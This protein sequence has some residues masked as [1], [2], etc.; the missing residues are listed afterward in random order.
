M[1]CGAGDPGRPGRLRARVA[2][3]PVEELGR[4]Y[5]RRELPAA[6]QE[7]LAGFLAR[8]GVHGTAEIDLGRQRWNE[9]PAPVLQ[10][11]QSYL[12]I[13]DPE[14]APDRI[15]ARGAAAGER[16]AGRLAASLRGGPHGRVRAA[17][18]RFAAGRVRALA[19]M[20]EYPKF[21]AVRLLGLAHDALLAS[22]A[23]L[24]KQGLLSAAGDVFFL[25]L[26]ELRELA[27]D[28]GGDAGRPQALVAERRAAYEREM[29]RTQIPRVLLS[30]GRA[31]YGGVAAAAG[32]AANTLAGSPVSP[33][34]AEGPVRVVFDP[35]QA[36]LRPGEILVCPGTDPAWTPLFLAAAG[37]VMEVGGLMTH[38]A[39]V[40]REYGI[41]AVASVYE[42]TTRL[43]TGQRVRVDGSN[44]VVRVLDD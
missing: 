35:H 30:D 40:A 24:A 41:P 28:A 14:A 44:G 2:D 43:R 9:D 18:A 16:A 17:L 6:A 1:G 42:A 37:L 21:F 34:V 36:Q 31:F 25:R 11:L 38:G 15:F 19:G 12:R 13:A 3:A 8:Y 7:A 22:G 5:R 32:E 23:E 39:V 4:A 27:R 10:S 26:D 33:G 29:R 20:R